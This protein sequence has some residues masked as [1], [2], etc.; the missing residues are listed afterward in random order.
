MYVFGRGEVKV[1]KFRIIYTLTLETI[2]CKVWT[3][4]DLQAFN[5]QSIIIF[6]FTVSFKI[7]TSIH[8]TWNWN[9]F[10][11]IAHK[12][13]LS[14]P[15][16]SSYFFIF[17]MVNKSYAIFERNAML[18]KTVFNEIFLL[19]QKLL[20]FKVIKFRPF[21]GIFCFNL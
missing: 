4:W 7:H 15:S 8:C 20:H 12:F 14:W 9:W 2:T 1:R 18:Y 5:G 3:K 21:S 6:T 19:K 16:N 10:S 13:I 11:E 17:Y